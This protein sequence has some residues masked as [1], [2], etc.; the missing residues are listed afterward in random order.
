LAHGAWR[1][2][3][4]G[5]GKGVIV[6]VDLDFIRIR[7]QAELFGCDYIGI[8]PDSAWVDDTEQSPQVLWPKTQSV[9]VLAM[10]I[11]EQTTAHRLLNELACKMALWLNSC[12]YPSVYIPIA[13]LSANMPK[14]APRLCFSHERAGELAGLDKSAI[15]ALGLVSV[16][17][18]W[19]YKI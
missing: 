6:P 10:D 19:R 11:G 9:I 14:G 5:A 8:A 12:G 1:E 2:F 18:E 15:P 13:D 4:S 17:T 3:A 7:E 16:L